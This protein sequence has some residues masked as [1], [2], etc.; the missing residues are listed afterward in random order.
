MKS[1]QWIVI[2][3]FMSSLTSV[4]AVDAQGSTDESAVWAVIEEQ[5]ERQE[6]GDRRWVEELLTADFTGWQNDAPAPRNKPSERM[7]NEFAMKQGKILEH[8][9]YPL[10]IIV[11]ADMAIAHYLYSQATENKGGD[12]NVTNGRFTD[13]LV[14]E[15]GRWRFISWHGGAD[16]G[17]D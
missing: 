5:W 8:E 17:N 1:K 7:W 10:S 16:P 11:H 3:A 14:R 13:V 4:T 6:R 2:L 15:E 9:L 12:V